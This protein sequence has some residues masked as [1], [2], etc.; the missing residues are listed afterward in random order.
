[1][2]E[3]LRSNQ[4]PTLEKSIADVR[5][6]LAALLAQLNRFVLFSK[7]RSVR[8]TVKLS[9]WGR[10]THPCYPYPRDA[11]GLLLFDIDRAALRNSVW[12]ARIASV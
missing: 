3:V 5:S 11:V 6:V 8:A 1:M 7:T 10:L 12:E 4:L 2:A 9:R